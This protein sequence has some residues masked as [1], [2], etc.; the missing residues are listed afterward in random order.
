M[1]ILLGALAGRPHEGLGLVVGDPEPLLQYIEESRLFG[2]LISVGER[3]KDS[4]LQ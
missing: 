3:Q 4:V 2:G 1:Q